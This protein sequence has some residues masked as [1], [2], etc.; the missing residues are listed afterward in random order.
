LWRHLRDRR[1]AGFK[2]RRQ[3]PIGRYIVDFVCFEAKVILELDGSQHAEEAQAERDCV[4]D[5]WLGSQG[6][7]V[8]R[9]WNTEVIKN[10]SGV[11]MKIREACQRTL[12]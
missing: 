8:L 5:E 12:T 9:F 6:F 3:S 1:L 11:L 2:F 7:E 10:V 4:R